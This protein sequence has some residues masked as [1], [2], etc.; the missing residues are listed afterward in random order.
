MNA[1]SLLIMTCGG[2]ITKGGSHA[3]KEFYTHLPAGPSLRRCDPSGPSPPPRPR[4]QVPRR[5]AA[6][7]VVLCRRPPHLAV[8]RLPVVARCPLRR[9][10]PLGPDRHPARLRRAAT[11]A[12]RRSGGEPAP[13]LAPPAAT[14]GRRLGPDPLSRRSPCT[15]PTRSTARR[16]RA[17]P[18]TSTPTP[19]CMSSTTATASPWR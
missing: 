2:V 19:R 14:P 4:T 7:V 9:G 11:S 6:D 16:P 5:A 8:G 12:Q 17:G 18:A 10:G 15:M 13:P 3:P 1:G